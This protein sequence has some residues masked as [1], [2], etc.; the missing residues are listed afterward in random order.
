MFEDNLKGFDSFYDHNNKIHFCC[1]RW[2]CLSINWTTVVSLFCSSYVC[3][4]YF[5]FWY[6]K[7]FILPV[8]SSVKF[9]EWVSFWQSIRNFRMFCFFSIKT[10]TLVFNQ[11]LSTEM[12]IFTDASLTQSLTIFQSTGKVI[13]CC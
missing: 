13:S 7:G 5:S 9:F 10:K 8:K 2:W 12:F 6:S 11:I 3:T 4:E 1:F